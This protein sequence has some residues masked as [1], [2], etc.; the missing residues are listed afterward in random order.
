MKSGKIQ[1]P[2]PAKDGGEW[3]KGALHT[4]TLWSD[5]RSLPEIALRTYRELGY[6]FV[7]LSD[8]NVFQEDP[9]VWRTVEPEEGPWPPSLSRRE[10]ERSRAMLPGG[11]DEKTVSFKTFVRLRTFR[12]LRK[13]FAEPGRFLL[14]PGEEITV[15]GLRFS[16]DE[17]RDIHLNVFNLEKQFP[18][19]SGKS[20][21]ETIGLNLQACRNAAAHTR[22]PSFSMLNHPFWRQWDILPEDALAFPELSVVEICN[23]GSEGKTPGGPV[24]P[25]QFWDILLAHRL[26]AGQGVIYA[27]AGDDA[28][29]YDPERRHVSAACDTAWVMVRCPG[30]FTA[31]SI[32]EAVLRGDFY[33]TCGVTFDSV[34]FDSCSGTLHVKAEEGSSCRIDFIT[35]KRG[36]DRTVAR[37]YYPN[38][39]KRLSRTLPSYSPEIGRI[40]KSV[41]GPEGSYAMAPDDLYVRAVAVSD[42][43]GRIQTPFYPETERAWTQPYA[44]VKR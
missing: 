17:I 26:E 21:E 22:H 7:C 8:H 29:Y 5:G 41:N 39:N 16:G 44:A 11:L 35:T 10:Y 15:M 14:I 6:D 23:C 12:E 2:S 36:F 27:S 9:Q 20:A 1:P 19:L 3:K 13:M 31:G 40:V 34:E 33:P 28:H 32:A 37:K 4:H 30:K 42:R 25:E 18:P 43:P 38:E 24:S